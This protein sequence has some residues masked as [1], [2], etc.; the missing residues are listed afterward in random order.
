MFHDRDGNGKVK[1]KNIC[2][3]IASLLH[4]QE[5]KK[6]TIGKISRMKIF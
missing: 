4:T 5:N 1:S 6:F 2:D 3:L